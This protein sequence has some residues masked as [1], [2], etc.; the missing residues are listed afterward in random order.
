LFQGKIKRRLNSGNACYHSVQNLLS[1][2]LLPKNVKIRI[3]KTII[4]PVVLYGCDTWSL[5][6][7]EKHRLR[8]FENR[9]LRK[10]LGPKSDEVTGGWMKLHYKDLRDLYS[11]PSIIRMIK[12]KRMRWEGNIARIREERYAY[13]LLV[14]KPEGQRPLGR[15]ICRWVDN[16]RM[17]L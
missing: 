5:T 16:M 2:R 14:G 10:I 1:S 8:V 6:L 15:P 11:S 13:R 4:L 7:R 9:M 3:Y 17:D 12:L